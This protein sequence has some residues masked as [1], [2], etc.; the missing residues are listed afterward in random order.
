[1]RPVNFDLRRRLMNE[2]DPMSVEKILEHM[3]DGV[4]KL[5]IM[6]QALGLRE[7]FGSYAPLPVTGEAQD[8]V[9]A[10]SRGEVA[11]IVPRSARDIVSWGETAVD[12]PSRSKWRNVLA[13][14]EIVSSPALLSGLFRRFPVALLAGY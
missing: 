10:F 8:Q 9:V 14:D 7:R 13:G 4:P 2:L 6:K 1:R 11:V 12:L 3:D 5:W